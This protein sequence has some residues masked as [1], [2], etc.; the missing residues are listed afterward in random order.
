M[1]P[2][3]SNSALSYRFSGQGARTCSKSQAVVPAAPRRQPYRSRARRLLLLGSTNTLED[4]TR[5]R[6]GAKNIGGDYP[7]LY[8]LA[9][10]TAAA[11]DPVRLRPCPPW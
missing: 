8:K 4:S 10:P 6:I 11:I 9:T 2:W 3:R 1:K 5:D 7:V